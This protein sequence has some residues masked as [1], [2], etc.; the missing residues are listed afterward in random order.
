M[1]TKLYRGNYISRLN[2]NQWNSLKMQILIIF[3]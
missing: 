3:L 1:S 2:E